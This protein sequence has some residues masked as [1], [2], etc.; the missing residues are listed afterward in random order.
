[1]LNLRAGIGTFRY[2]NSIDRVIGQQGAK[3]DRPTWLA[4]LRQSGADIDTIVASLQR[5]GIIT[6]PGYWSAEKCAT[7][8]AEIDRLVADYP[9]SV[10]NFSGG[11][12]KRMFGV[13]AV[14]PL[15]AEF[16]ADPFLRDMGEFLGGAELYNFATLGARIDATSANNGSGDGWHRDGFGFQ[17]K[18][19]LY[20]SD[21]TEDNG[22]F[23]FLPG[24]HTGWRAAFDTAVGRLP[25]APSSRYE[26]ADIDQLVGRFGIT[27]QHFAAKAGTLILVNTSGIHRGCPLRAGTRYALTNYFFHPFQIDEG[28]IEKFAPLMPGAADR[29]RADLLTG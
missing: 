27:R 14:S 4:R 13:E 2:W 1:M 26:P 10:R 16:H 23:E 29:V 15:L 11:A 22:P 6:L 7:G 8:R 3:V 9:D 17:F 20:L 18:S 12:D 28:R 25:A 24:S 21:V 19:I 5:D